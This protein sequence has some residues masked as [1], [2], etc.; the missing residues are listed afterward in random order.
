[1]EG[2]V[3]VGGGGRGGTPLLYT[4]SCCSAMLRGDAVH[5]CLP[6]PPILADS[7]CR[8]SDSLQRESTVHTSPPRA[9]NKLLHSLGGEGLPLPFPVLVFL[10]SAP[11]N[12]MINFEKRG[13]GRRLLRFSAAAQM[14]DAPPSLAQ[15][16]IMPSGGRERW[17]AYTH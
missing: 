9:R 6:P 7:V 2:R 5:P 11:S 14:N 13:L 17:G 4:Q 3:K 8:N 16:T 10:V 15:K 12:A 1:M